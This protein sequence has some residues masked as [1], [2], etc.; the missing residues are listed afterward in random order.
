[1]IDAIEHAARKSSGR[2]PYASAATDEGIAVRQNSLR[3]LLRSGAPTLGTHLFLNDPAVVEIVGQTG[4]FDYVEFLAEYAPYDMRGLEDHCRAAELHGLGSMIKVDYES[5]AFVAQRGVGAG[6]EAV[7]FTDARSADDVR[8]MIRAVRPDTP[9]QGGRYGVAVRRNARPAYIGSQAYIDALNDV[10][11]AVMIEKAAAVECLDEILA[12]PG[13][14][15]VQWGP[16][17]YALSA[18]LPGPTDPRVRE[19][20]R[21][22]IETC[23]AAGVPCRAAPRSAAS[24]PRRTTPTSACATSASAGTSGSCTTR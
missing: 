23:H 11:V 2:P 7:L 22:V 14:D 13:I 18:G 16:A 1:M 20:E 15:L 4:A 17:D 3:S 10:V 6:F 21:R 19:V 5:R 12:V 8:G 9:E 24:T